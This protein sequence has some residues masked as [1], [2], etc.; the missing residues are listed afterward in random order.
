[1]KKIL[2]FTLSL[3][4]AMQLLSEQ[5]LDAKLFLPEEYK[6]IAN[7]TFELFFDGII[8]D[9]DPSDYEVRVE[10]PIG[11]LHYAHKFMWRPTAAQVGNHVVSI[12]LFDRSGTM[13]ETREIVLKVAPAIEVSPSKPV[14]ILCIGDSLTADGEWIL[15]LNRRLTDIGGAPEGRGLSNINFVGRRKIPGTEVGHEGNSGWGYYN[16][17]DNFDYH[18][19]FAVKVDSQEVL[20]NA[21]VGSGWRANNGTF[22]EIKAINRE[23]MLL[24][25]GYYSRFGLPPERGTLTWQ[26]GRAPDLGQ[27]EF[28]VVK[29]ISSNPFWNEETKSIDIRNYV[30]NV[31]GAPQLDYCYIFL[32]WNHI[33]TPPKDMMDGCNRLTA[34]I[35]EAYP[36]CR[37]VQIGLPRPVREAMGFDRNPLR[38]SYLSLLKWSF[39]DF[40][41]KLSAIS[42]NHTNVDVLHLS[43]QV[44]STNHAQTAEFK[45]DLR[46]PRAET[47][48]SAVFHLSKS[49]YMQVA[50]AVYRDL[51]YRL[52]TAAQ[53]Q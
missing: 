41:W 28:E 25:L 42:K 38:V 44:D 6:I 7:D 48:P 4:A 17:A 26:R 52:S 53:Q 3:V 18:H 33:N 43:G 24:Y 15:E 35:R 50:D 49:G 30:N 9:I 31:A 20:D 51:M 39:L 8:M 13:I 40:Q 10:P 19:R 32:G 12:N 29:V 14:Y 23:E 5:L 37:I 16:Y 34:L 36:E 2:I 46:S 22:W 11:G 21:Y 45:S 27:I 1:M 47:M